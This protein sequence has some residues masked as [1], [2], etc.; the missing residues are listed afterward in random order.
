MLEVESPDVVREKGETA[1]VG[2]KSFAYREE[3]L[4]SLMEKFVYLYEGG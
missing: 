4:F 1:R 3:H 2:R